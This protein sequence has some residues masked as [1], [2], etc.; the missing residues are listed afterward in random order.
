[1]RK[2]GREKKETKEGKK[3]ASAKA[4]FGVSQTKNYFFWFTSIGVLRDP[5]QLKCRLLRFFTRK[6]CVKEVLET[7]YLTQRKQYLK[8][9]TL[10]RLKIPLQ[11]ICIKE[12]PHYC[13]SEA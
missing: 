5:S 13:L 1:M 9:T 12:G 4:T 2:S 11:T 10:R 7:D 3:V 6:P 8:R